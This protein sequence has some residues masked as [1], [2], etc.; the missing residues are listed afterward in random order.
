MRER[1][2]PIAAP[3]LRALLGELRAPL[4]VASFLLG[5]TQ[6]RA[7]PPGDGHPVM[8]LP[9]FGMGD[10]ALA[11]MAR[12]IERL[13]YAVY[14]WEQGRNFGLRQRTAER[15]LERLLDLHRRHARAVSLVGWSAGGLYARELARLRPDRVRRVF[16]LGSPLQPHASGQPLV[17]LARQWFDAHLTAQGD[18]PLA[19][20]VDALQLPCTVIH[21][22]SDGVVAWRAAVQD[23]APHTENLEVDGTHLGLGFNLEVLRIIAE[24]LALE[25]AG[26]PPKAPPKR[27]RTPA[28]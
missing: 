20:N 7:L 10:E 23:D 11:P 24:R 2:R 27:R 16:T 18:S 9:G 28:P 22:K 13:G 12:A 19:P 3:D 6:L 25:P 21:S 8:F 14:G 17:E 15:L 26:R 4:E 5:A 1:D